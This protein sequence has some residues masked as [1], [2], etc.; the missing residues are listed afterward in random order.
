MNR[1]AAKQR[2]KR[3][4]PVLIVLVVLGLLG[5][6]WLAS[7]SAD[8][9]SL[10]ASGTVEATE[11]HL[12]FPAGGLLARV[13]V[14]EGERVEEGQPLAWLD[15]T[16]SRA[17]RAQAAAQANA[18]RARLAE[19]EGG[20]RSEEVAQARAALEGADRQLDE[21][22]LALGRTQKLLEGGA[23]SQEDYDKAAVARDVARSRR[24]QAAQQLGLLR[25]GPP[26]E[27]I[28]AQRAMVEQAEASVA[29][30]DAALALMVVRAPFAG[31]V[32]VRHREPGE[33]VAP[34]SPVLTVLDPTDRW[35]RIYVP[36]P[37]LGSVALGAPA[38][39]TS[40]TYQD[41]DYRGEVRFIASEAEFTPKTVQTAEERVKLVYAV[42]VAI[43]GDSAF[44]LK[45]GMPADV[46][47]E[48]S[49]D[50]AR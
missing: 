23:A 41:R 39:I 47:L 9:G 24:A 48:S 3:V 17:R 6:R 42:K 2:M 4:V 13:E 11:A 16:E 21:A 19:L 8:G 29:G 35:V 5:R 7:R 28:A 44:E 1:A 33:I 50:A 32:T 38:A 18:A 25:S 20:Y 40:D 27:Q 46:R 45:P 34:G 30:F 43:T 15:D 36:E 10:V 49:D 22:E 14:R 26:R 12:G 37:R 31:V